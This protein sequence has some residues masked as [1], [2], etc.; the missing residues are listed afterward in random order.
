MLIEFLTILLVAEKVKGLLMPGVLIADFVKK[1]VYPHAWYIRFLAILF[2]F[3]FT[4]LFSSNIKAESKYAEIPDKVRFH[5]MIDHESEFLGEILSVAQDSYGFLWFGGKNGLGRFDGYDYKI[6]RHNANNSK[7]ISNNVVNDIVVD[8]ND[9]LWIATDQGVN[10]FDRQY[11]QFTH[12]KHIKDEPASLIHNRAISL[13]KEGEHT[14]WIGGDGGLQ[15]LNLLTKKIT[16]YPNSESSESEQKL[17]GPYV[18]GLHVEGTKVYLGSG[19]GLTIWDRSTKTA[20]VWGGSPL[21]E[22]MPSAMLRDVFVDS[23][24]RVWLGS[25]RGLARFDETTQKFTAYPSPN[26]ILNGTRTPVWKVIED[27]NGEIWAASDGN[28]AYRLKVGASSIMNYPT[29]NRNPFS[30]QSPV[31]RTLLEDNVGDLWF[32]LYPAGVDSVTRYNAAFTTHLNISDDE[33]SIN[34]NNVSAILEDEAQNLWLGA[35]GGGLNYFDTRTGTYSF[36]VH[37][38]DDDKT[39]ASNSIMRMV[40]SENELWLALFNGGVSKINLTDGK[41]T[42]YPVKLNVPG[43]LYNLHNFALHVDIRGDIWVGSMGNGIAKYDRG[44]DV[45]NHIEYDPPNNTMG[46]ERVWSISGDKHGN[47][48][49][50]THNGLV[51]Y[52]PETKEFK[53]YLHDPDEQSSISDYWVTAVIED[54]KNRLWVG[55]HGGGL[56]LFDPL[57]EKF[58]R[59]QQDDGLSSNIIYAMELD[60]EGDLWMSTNR[61]LIRY[62]TELKEVLNF[63]SENGLQGNQFTLGS[64]TKTKNGDLIFGG[65]NGYTRFNPLSLT[66]N[67]EKP[68]VVFTQ[69]TVEEKPIDLDVSEVISENILTAKEIVLNHKQ[70]VFTLGF[71][72]LNY[73]IASKNQYAFKLEGFDKDWNYAGTKRFKSYTNLDPGK[74]TFRVKAANNEGVWNHEGIAI[75]VQI[76]PPPW[77]TW[78]AFLSYIITIILIVAWYIHSQK[79]IAVQNSL[80]SQ[81]QEVDKIKDEFIASTSHELRTPLFGIIGLA[82]T[83]LENAENSISTRDKN[84]IR[85]IISSGNRLITQ[86]N[87]ILDYAKIKNNAL[88]ITKK[89]VSLYDLCEL[90]IPL[91][92]QII[93]SKNIKIINKIQQKLP[94]VLADPHRLQ[95]ILINLVANAIHNTQHGTVSIDAVLVNNEVQ[96]SI[97]DTGKGIPKEKIPDLFEQFTQLDNVNSREQKG[98]GLGLPITKKLIELQNGRIWVESKP[99]IGSTF[100]FSLPISREAPIKAEIDDRERSRLAVLTDRNQSKSSTQESHKAELERLNSK[101][102]NQDVINGHVLIVDDEKVNRI[103]LSAYLKGEPYSITEADSGD[104]A[105]EIL[106]KDE[107]I[108]II[109]L[110][111]MMPGLSGFDTC[112]LVRS[113]FPGRRIS[114]IFSTA[115]GNA[116][117]MSYAFEI[118]GNDFVN[119]PVTKNELRARIRL[120]AKSHGNENHT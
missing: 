54:D 27:S 21:P 38:P 111:V 68:N 104:E 59:I 116:D 87:D 19:A 109:L 46:T 94:S 5:H 102:K 32:G 15:S 45:F 114:I 65:S 120:H 106:A 71:A 13:F 23:Q 89:P 99:G 82:E 55:T 62:D 25:E 79:K 119:K 2:L 117:D 33:T 113:K 18:M 22:N 43:N 29:N 1:V 50:G 9:N 41:V 24:K 17:A 86:V 103:V 44:R 66:P 30:P 78:W 16:R 93:Y 53:R 7:S 110:D 118:G 76:I 31:F 14:L 83:T 47:L 77:R 40:K 35:D 28:G 3:L 108:N 42:N 51:K 112:K 69:L 100:T 11:Q 70:N 88:K 56:N 97:T 63:G 39:I 105:L 37:I 4:Y 92:N 52:H 101:T 98:T 26:D 60:N 20:N 96:I 85:M 80:V 49:I 95:Q 74:Y 115:K 36:T 58:Q 8:E 10:F 107:S 84:N 73:R 75:D 64:S 12:Y 57:T 91:T 61:G 81:L 48:W 6:Y 67:S 72:A 90:V 34:A